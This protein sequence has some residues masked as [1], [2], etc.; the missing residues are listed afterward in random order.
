M[1]HLEL[2]AACA[3]SCISCLAIGVSSLAI[4]KPFI[5]EYLEKR[6][7]Q[8]AITEPWFPPQNVAGAQNTVNAVQAFMNNK[9]RRK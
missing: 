2:I 3:A 7:R 6:K 9:R 8:T 4:V 5:D 1:E